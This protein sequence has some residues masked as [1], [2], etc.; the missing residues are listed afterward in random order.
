MHAI[1]THGRY[2]L[3]PTLGG[4]GFHSLLFENLEAKE[5]EFWVEIKGVGALK[6]KR[7]GP[8]IFEAAE[9]RPHNGLLLDP[10]VSE[11]LLSDKI[12]G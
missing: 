2:E 5:E 4:K 12:K 3:L 6:L 11:R 8:H 1:S 10:Q 7:V 9:L